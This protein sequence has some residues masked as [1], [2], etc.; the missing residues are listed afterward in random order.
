VADVFVKRLSVALRYNLIHF[1]VRKSTRH[2]LDFAFLMLKL[3]TKP[4]KFSIYQVNEKESVRFQ[5]CL[6]Y[7]NVCD[8]LFIINH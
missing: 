2:S 5:S 7:G 1:S 8:G 3:F 6:V 4:F